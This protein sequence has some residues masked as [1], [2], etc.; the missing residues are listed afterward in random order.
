MA[1]GA[2]QKLKISDCK[3]FSIVLQIKISVTDRVK[4]NITT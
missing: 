1:I 4:R 2:K 3:I